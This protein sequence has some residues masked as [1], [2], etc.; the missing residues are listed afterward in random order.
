MKLNKIFSVLT[1]LITINSNC[2]ANNHAVIVPKKIKEI[3]NC[4]CEKKVFLCPAKALKN[5]ENINNWEGF[6]QCVS[7]C[8]EENK[9]AI[10]AH[11]VT[12]Q[13]LE[14]DCSDYCASYADESGGYADKK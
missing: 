3:N 14:L 12:K 5:E 7:S 8:L 10:K 11:D 13:E 4:K 6:C 9:A 1:L 2:Y